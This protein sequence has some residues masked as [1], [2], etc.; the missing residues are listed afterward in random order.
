MKIELHRS[1]DLY[2]SLVSNPLSSIHFPT[3]SLPPPLAKEGFN[4]LH[5]PDCCLLPSWSSHQRSC[6]LTFRT[7]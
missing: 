3:L 4:S 6:L 2:L 7:L 1:V 5:Y